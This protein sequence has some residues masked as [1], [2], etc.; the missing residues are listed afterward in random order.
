MMA[1][2]SG[3]RAPVRSRGRERTQVATV[4]TGLHLG[5]LWYRTYPSVNLKVFNL[6]WFS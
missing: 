6:L 4:A 3:D 5:E 2:S 1:R